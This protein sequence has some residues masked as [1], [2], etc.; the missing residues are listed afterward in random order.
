MNSD[1]LEPGS[2]L[3][4]ARLSFDPIALIES[5]Y[6]HH[7]DAASWL[8]RVTEEVVQAVDPTC[9]AAV[10]YVLGSRGPESPK[11]ALSIGRA[12][13]QEIEMMVA[14]GWRAS[15]PENTRVMWEACRKPGINSLRQILG[16]GVVDRWLAGIRDWPLPLEDSVAVLL[17][18]SQGKPLLLTLACARPLRIRASEHA[19]W[20]RIAIHL[21]AGWRLAGRAA[22]SDAA[23]VEAVLTPGGRIEHARGA[24]AT[25]HAGEA[26]RRAT[27]H[28]DRA[29][30]RR[31][32]ADPFAALELW[33]GLFAGRWS[34][35]EHFD[36]DGK[37]FL[38]A[39]RN[40]PALADPL[41]LTSRQ[42][43]VV[44]YASLGLS[45]KEVAYA[46]GLAE[47]TVSAHLSAGLA[48]LRI[49]SRA[50]LIRTSSELALEGLSALTDT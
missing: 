40:D 35:V 17:S 14:E 5:G 15:S 39:R 43:Q 49:K 26:L 37:R 1:R 8:Q 25:A 13:L 46:L 45:T 6:E 50:E 21:S 2:C 4:E 36:S 20:H 41:A 31:G 18:G 11:A 48:R 28:I 7:A 44:F 27:L 33:Q 24:A 47:N 22:T 42:R 29:R 12:S 3:V 9:L 23:D 10:S 32:R 16:D 19:L 38:L 34:L 30:T